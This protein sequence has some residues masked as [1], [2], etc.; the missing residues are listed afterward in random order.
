MRVLITSRLGLRGVL[1]IAAFMWAGIYLSCKHVSAVVATELG[2][3]HDS[4]FVGT[5][6]RTLWAVVGVAAYATRVVCT[7]T[8]VALIGIV[9]TAGRDGGSQQA[10][11]AVQR[12]GPRSLLSDRFHTSKL[13]EHVDAI[14][15]GSGMSGLSCAA[16]LAQAGR[17]V[18]VL[19][20]VWLTVSACYKCNSFDV[21]DTHTC[22]SRP[23]EHCI[24]AEVELHMSRDDVSANASSNCLRRKN[25]RMACLLSTDHGPVLNATP[26]HPFPC[27]FSMMWQVVV[28]IRTSSAVDTSLTRVFTVRVCVSPCMHACI[29]DML[30]VRLSC[31]SFTFG[32]QEIKILVAFFLCCSI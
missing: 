27:C 22:S 10:D 20:Q 31:V 8:A 1:V 9:T 25:D 4:T 11:G 19:E 6:T 14:V 28:P 17:R 3:A 29:C 18:L 13:P 5:L 15:V 32:V 23:L 7:L 12:S 30:T 24:L 16:L 2:S 26:S 21:D